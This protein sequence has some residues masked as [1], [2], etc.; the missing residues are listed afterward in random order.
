MEV[1]THKK[2]SIATDVQQAYS[3]KLLR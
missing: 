3:M 2:F 1:A